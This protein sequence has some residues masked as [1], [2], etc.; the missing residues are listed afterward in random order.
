MS[1]NG[2]ARPPP[3]NPETGFSGTTFDDILF[4]AHRSQTGRDNGRTDFIERKFPD[5]LGF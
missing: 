2:L 3:N 5:I 1:E 4:N